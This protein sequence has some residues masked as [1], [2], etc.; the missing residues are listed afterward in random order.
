M[1][2]PQG[3]DLLKGLSKPVNIQKEMEKL[4][5][6]KAAQK[7]YLKKLKSMRTKITG[8][9][10]FSEEE[11]LGNGD[12]EKLTFDYMVENMKFVRHPNPKL[13]W[14]VTTAILFS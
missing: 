7:E 13:K 10:N 9:P 3:A 4:E 6:D 11:V 14:M 5:K 12:E 8:D 1:H 2:L